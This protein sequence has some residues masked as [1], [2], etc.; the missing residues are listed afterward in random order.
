MLKQQQMRKFFRRDLRPRRDANG[1]SSRRAL[2]LLR[3]TALAV[4]LGGFLALSNAELRAQ[5]RPSSPES[6]PASTVRTRSAYGA[7]STAPKTA[8]T[9][10]PERSAEREAFDRLNFPTKN[11]RCSQKTFAAPDRADAAL[12]G[13]Y[14]SRLLPKSL[15]DETFWRYDKEANTITVYGPEA[16]LTVVDELLTQF[17]KDDYDAHVA[18]QFQLVATAGF[19]EREDAPSRVAP[20][21]GY[22]AQ[23]RRVSDE[24][25]Y[26]P[27][28]NDFVRVAYDA[29]SAILPPQN[30]AVVFGAEVAAENAP[31]FA[32][33]LLGSTAPAA[34]REDSALEIVSYRCL[35][36]RVDEIEALARREF[37][38]ISE[39]AFSVDRQLGTIVVHTNRKLQ[40]AVQ[41]YF[42]S[43]QI[44]PTT[45]APGQPDPRVA[46]GVL[47]PIDGVDSI[48]PVGDRVARQAFGGS[49]PAPRFASPAVSGSANDVYA[50][51]FRK[52]TELRE[53]LVGLF[54]ARFQ[55]LEKN[56]AADAPFS[57]RQIE[58]RRF[59]KRQTPGES[60]VRVCDVS[61]DSV[62]NSISLDGDAAICSQMLV[63]LRAM[64][65]PPAAPGVVR[66]FIPIQ[67][68]DSNKIRQIFESGATPAPTAPLGR[69]DVG[70]FGRELA[71]SELVRRLTT[72]SA[73]TPFERFAPYFAD[74]APALPA[75]ETALA[76][77]ASNAIRQAAYQEDGGLGALGAADAPLGGLGDFSAAD[78]TGR[79]GVGVVQDFVP[80][81][82]DAI[83][84]IVVDNA[85]DAEFERIRQMI[86]QI[87]ELAKIADPTIEVYMMRH[88]DGAMLHGVLTKLYAEMFATKQGRVMFYA[89]QNPNAILVVGWG[90]A[91]EDMKN[92][93]EVFD[94][95]IAE[96]TGTLRVV[97]LKH[98]S[99]TEIAALL[100]EAFPAPIVDGTGGFAPRINVFSDV[101]TNS[102]VV[103]ASPNDWLEIEKLLVELDVNTTSA[104]LVTRVIPL[105]NSLAEDILTTIQNAI[106]PAKQG[107]LET[108]AAK[109]PVLELLSVDET[110]QRLIQSGV[111]MDVEVSADV[112][113]NQLIVNAP[114][115]CMEFMEK[116]IEVLDVAPKKAEI[117]F[118]QVRHGDAQAIMQ[119]LQSLLATSDNNLATPTLP[120]AAGEE[121][122]FVPVRFAIDTRTN[123]IIA[124]AAPRELAIVDAL[125]V[126]LDVQD[127]TERVEEVVQL[128]NIRAD[129]VAS[130]IDDYL[131][132]KQ[133]LETLSEVLTT[134]QLYESQVIVIPESISNSIIVSASPEHMEK[135]LDMIKTF[136]ADPPQV[137][138]QV[139]IAEV[140]LTDQEEFGIEAG[141]QDASSFD[142]S[143]ITNAG[144]GGATGSPGFNIVNGSGPGE[145][146]NSGV[147]ATNIAG[148]VLNNF[149]MGASSSSLGYGGFVLSASSRS[150][151][152]TL[153]ALREKNRLQILSRPQITAMDNQQAFILVGQR[154]PRI[155]GTT[156]TNYGVQMNTVDTPVGLILLVTPRVTKDG[157]VVMEIGAEKSSLGNDADA[158]PIYSQDG[159]VIKSQSIDTIQAM[160]AISARDG[161]TVMLGGLLT[162]TKEKISRGVPYLSDIPGLGWLFRYD[163]EREQRKEL[164]IVMTPRI[165]RTPE[166]FEEIVRVEVGKTN[167]NLSEAFEINGDM[168]L[169]DAAT[170]QG[171]ETKK[172][173]NIVNDLMHPDQMNELKEG[174]EYD[175]SRDYKKR[176][177]T[178]VPTTK[179][180]SSAR[181]S[182]TRIA[183][184]RTT[185]SRSTESRA[186]A[187]SRRPAI[188]AASTESDDE[189]TFILMDD[190]DFA[191]RSTRRDA[192]VRAASAE[193][194]STATKVARAETEASRSTAKATDAKSSTARKTS[195]TKADAAEKRASESTRSKASATS[196][197]G[198][199]PEEKEPL[200]KN[201][202][203]FAF[204]W[205]RSK[206]EKTG[207]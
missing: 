95:P 40:R 73:A 91:F 182:S 29:D 183:T 124:A 59:V 36:T 21:S 16:A 70:D 173:R 68:G 103:Q 56:A 112:Y 18:G 44:Y 181:N 28:R 35:P 176:S 34:S 132:Q 174:Q 15:R 207:A 184:P 138:I 186:A 89:L 74:V 202:R 42:A 100:T 25:T 33:P 159:E 195:T 24:K 14:F 166:D 31:T 115:D 78:E 131:A 170:N 49:T 200:L 157:R 27:D 163:Q 167:V 22:E 162:S 101:R 48:E 43:L 196:V 204:P 41:K 172:T 7:A 185:T 3:A 23:E 134:Y 61:F 153:R 189:P 87:E 203:G 62:R 199:A 93:I 51:Q 116:L 127:A 178:T 50:P 197:R 52:A 38:S 133:Q 32:P 39:I 12:L 114:E 84:V 2:G 53:M 187:E 151:D 83:D 201:P 20:T 92:L 190:D 76:S 171:R 9:P 79:P 88:V 85:T 121:E 145:N 198:A 109:F 69:A 71:Q 188:P 64:D 13:G 106:L 158:V 205:I 141:L 45:L 161:E 30:E 206:A 154:V 99:T 75:I 143:L 1:R 168:G 8:Q 98:A 77:N 54:G 72:A 192:A 37:S 125:I 97:R 129:V 19:V 17:N 55:T 107:T 90:Q 164:L 119:T 139:L 150:V 191:V 147:P 57:E 58:T 175:P 146:I 120:Q 144:T 113:H 180:T 102:L 193:N 137:V 135:I 136:D 11:G 155:D 6:K 67:H 152:V 122:T 130:A 105:K 128:R 81:V 4:A 86:E 10:T 96:G 5:T 66:R 142:R 80:L 179:K 165:L 65:Q 123:V 60:E 108:D 194:R 110:G 140:T 177:Q 169:Y 148:Q 149:G 156:T 117:R 63:L 104:K 46:T 160:T 26:D 118:F 126:A 111:M 47:R 82:L 94:K